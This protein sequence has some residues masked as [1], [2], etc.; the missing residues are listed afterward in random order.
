VLVALGDVDGWVAALT[1]V[2]GDHERRR[3]L[4]E[5]GRIRAQGFSWERSATATRDVYREA[6]AR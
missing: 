5:A 3:D 1:A 4:G 2:I 6:I